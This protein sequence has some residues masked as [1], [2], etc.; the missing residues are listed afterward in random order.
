MFEAANKMTIS[1]FS[2]IILLVLRLTFSP[3]NDR[4]EYLVLKQLLNTGTEKLD[5]QHK[6]NFPVERTRK[7]K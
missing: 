2:V 5:F 7:I 3:K 6:G 4:S 1:V